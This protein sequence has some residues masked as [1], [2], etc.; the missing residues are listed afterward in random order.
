MLF[1]NFVLTIASV[2]YLSAVATAQQVDYRPILTGL[3]LEVTYLKGASPTYQ[4]VPWAD[5][6]KDGDWYS[7]FRRIADWQLPAGTLPIRAVKLVPSLKGET[8]IIAVSVLRGARHDVEETV[9]TYR[10]RENETISL[11]AL[12]TF[13]VD[14]F[15]I[16]VVRVVPASSSRPTIINRTKS[17]EVVGLEPLISSIPAFKMTLHNLSDKKISA[18]TLNVVRNGMNA[19]TGMPQGADGKPAIESGG[20]AEFRL[21]LREEARSSPAGYELVAPPNQ[22]IAISSVVFEDGSYEGDPK[23]AAEYRAFALGR[24][25]EMKRFLPMLQGALDANDSDNANAPSRLRSSLRAL[26]FETDIADFAAL[27]QAFPSISQKSLSSAAQS[28]IHGLRKG[29][30]DELQSFQDGNSVPPHDFRSW[31]TATNERYANWL[32]RL[33][34]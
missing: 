32:A 11:D 14:P 3:V 18:L 16:K 10:T 27:F 7:R 34:K 23:L 15:I 17:V 1:R 6:K 22:Q 30:L 2:I 26:S 8:V 20:Y 4:I 29:L 13:G 31:L 25:I 19:V 24:K 5:E 21:P 12:K 9:S 28:S 33:D